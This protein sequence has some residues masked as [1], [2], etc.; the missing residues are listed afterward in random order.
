MI[1]STPG[2]AGGCLLLSSMGKETA[3]H[4]ERF[5]RDQGKLLESEAADIV[6]RQDR[7]PGDRLPWIQRSLTFGGSLKMVECG[8]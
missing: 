3:P 8:P 5:A 4:S 1:S 7:F 6:S 2:P